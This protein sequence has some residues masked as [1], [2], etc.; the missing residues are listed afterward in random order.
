[1]RITSEVPSRAS[2]RM[3]LVPALV[4]IAALCSLYSGHSNR[5]CSTVSCP[6]PQ[7]QRD[8]S[9]RPNQ[10]RCELRPQCPVFS[11]MIFPHVFRGSF[12]YRVGRCSL[13]FRWR[14]RLS[15]D[16][17]GFVLRLVHCSY[18]VAFICQI[19]DCSFH[20]RIVFIAIRWTVVSF[21]ACI[22][23]AVTS[24]SKF[25]HVGLVT[26]KHV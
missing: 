24:V 17:G 20:N 25:R 19:R 26:S 16:E 11:C 12:L 3:F 13:S 18:A 14:I 2:A 9:A 15:H 23:C 8:L 5:K 1:M 21:W 10:C 22:E 4:L 7:S 6:V